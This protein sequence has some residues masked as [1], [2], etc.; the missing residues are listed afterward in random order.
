MADAFHHHEK[1]DTWKL[2]VDLA[3]EVYRVTAEFPR[4][5]RFRLVDQM[6][7]ASVS[8]LSNFSEGA[9][10]GSNRQYIKFLGIARGS[11]T[12]LAAQTVLA[13]RLGFLDESTY[14]VLRTLCHRVAAGLSGLIRYQKSKL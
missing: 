1:L 8:V 13:M 2:A 3:E 10:Y 5:Q 7:R 6:Q 14:D 4:D 9:S 11:T 12:E